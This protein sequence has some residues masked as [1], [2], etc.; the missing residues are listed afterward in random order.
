LF[1]LLDAAAAA[2]AASAEEIIFMLAL[3]RP[4]LSEFARMSVEAATF[5]ARKRFFFNVNP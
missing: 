3:A 4:F 1:R 2:V 5:L